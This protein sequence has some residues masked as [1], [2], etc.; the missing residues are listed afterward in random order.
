MGSVRWEDVALGNGFTSGNYALT[1][2]DDFR[3]YTWDLPW[4]GPC[5]PGLAGNL[6]AID[7]EHHITAVDAATGLVTMTATGQVFAHPQ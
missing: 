7:A 2:G 4:M 6:V 3:S 5:V 1:V